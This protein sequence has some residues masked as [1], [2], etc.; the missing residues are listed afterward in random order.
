MSQN[1]S[2]K[3]LEELSANGASIKLCDYKKMQSI[4]RRYFC[5][6]HKDAVEKT[7][8]AS[9]KKQFITPNF[10]DI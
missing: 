5:D 10:E 4:I 3:L 6:I 2:H 7:I 8:I 1:I 9:N